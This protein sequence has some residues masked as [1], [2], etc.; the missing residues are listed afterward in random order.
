MFVFSLMYLKK[1][2]ELFFEIIH[3]ENMIVYILNNEQKNRTQ[4]EVLEVQ[5]LQIY[6]IYILHVLNM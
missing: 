2:Y 1:K 6:L 4:Y 5:T 3:L